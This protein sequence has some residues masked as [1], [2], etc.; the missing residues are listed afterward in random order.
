MYGDTFE[1]DALSIAFP[2]TIETGLACL[3]A[4]LSKCKS[5]LILFL[6]AV[7]SLLISPKSVYPYFTTDLSI[8]AASCFTSST[9]QIISFNLGKYSSSKATKILGINGSI[10]VRADSFA[11][12][13]APVALLASSTAAIFM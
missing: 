5:W 3:S 7:A 10:N 12:K 13:S 4:H 11:F 1:P 8:A 6:A 2:F 9:S